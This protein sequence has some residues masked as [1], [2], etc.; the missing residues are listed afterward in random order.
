MSD[1][2]TQTLSPSAAAS[3]SASSLIPIEI[4][5]ADV[6]RCL[7]QFEVLEAIGAG[8]V[9]CVFKAKQRV[10][11]RPV[12][13]KILR[14]EW[15]GDV[16]FIER[17]RREACTLGA[18]K[19]SGIVT[20]YDS[21]ESG[22][23]FYI[24]MEY[25][26]GSSLRK[27]MDQGPVKPERARQIV[28]EL[29]AALASAHAAH[30]I[31]RDIKP[32]NILI[33]S[34]GALKLCDF[35]LS[36]IHRGNSTEYTLTTPD[37]RMGTPVYVAPE[38]WEDPVNADA[39]ADIYSLGVVIY[40]MLVGRKPIG[41]FPPA[42]K[43]A[44]LSS[45]LDDVIGR[46]MNADRELRFKTVDEFHAALARAWKPRVTARRIAPLAAV[47]VLLA[48]AAFSVQPIRKHFAAQ[49]AEKTAP[50]KIM[51]F[52]PPPSAVPAAPVDPDTFQDCEY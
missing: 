43:T 22:G 24:V 51:Y 13:L 3:G 15:A 19:H 47:A 35:G 23:L 49:K 1:Q 9:G 6:G 25:V 7:P 32:S 37:V 52:A 18:L 16:S 44:G 11:N 48:S 26:D 17:F 36:K 38:Q 45:K 33:D 2:V 42:S 29:C 50:K 41:N 31:H 46:A 40:E 34:K 12:A 30:V 28:D 39:R 5:P 27:I 21:G 20:V 10:L 4:S 14:D 8:G